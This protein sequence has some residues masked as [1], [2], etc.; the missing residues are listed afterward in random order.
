M[1]ICIRKENDKNKSHD[2]FNNK[3]KKI[4]LETEKQFFRRIIILFKKK[5][6]YTS[7]FPFPE[8]IYDFD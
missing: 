5:T 7:S 4:P 3:K 1:V 6:K 2:L 8:E